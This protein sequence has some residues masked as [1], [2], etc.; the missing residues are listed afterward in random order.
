MFMAPQRRHPAASAVMRVQAK[1]RARRQRIEDRFRFGSTMAERLS[2]SGPL[3]LAF[4]GI[5]WH[6]RITCLGGPFFIGAGVTIRLAIGGCLR[7][8]RVARFGR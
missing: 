1:V 6:S 5:W 8:F 7:F 3:S 4:A 2:C